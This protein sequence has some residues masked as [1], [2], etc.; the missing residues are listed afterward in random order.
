MRSINEVDVICVGGDVGL[1]FYR[2]IIFVLKPDEKLK[3]TFDAQNLQNRRLNQ[4]ENIAFH[5]KKKLKIDSYSQH[6]GRL[7]FW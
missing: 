6:Q 2:D 3:R 1:W 7:E 4:I 5:S